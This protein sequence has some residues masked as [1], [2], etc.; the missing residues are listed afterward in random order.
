MGWGGGD[1]IR[2]NATKHEMFFSDGGSDPSQLYEKDG[3]KSTSPCFQNERVCV[4]M[5]LAWEGSWDQV[6]TGEGLALQPDRLG[7]KYQPHHLLKVLRLL[8]V[9]KFLFSHLL[10]GAD[11]VFIVR[12]SRKAEQQVPGKATAI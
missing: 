11:V 6:F 5:N 7:F 8:A 10:N 3:P 9:F 12:F 1:R 4:C 2:G